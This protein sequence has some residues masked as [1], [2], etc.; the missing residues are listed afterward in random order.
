MGCQHTCVTSRCCTAKCVDNLLLYSRRSVN[1][2]ATT[3]E[4]LLNSILGHL[5]VAIPIAKALYQLTYEEL[6]NIHYTAD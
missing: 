6:A 3:L 4:G 2:C 1:N 5:Q